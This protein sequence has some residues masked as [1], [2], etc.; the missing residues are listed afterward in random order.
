LPPI[1]EITVNSL[2]SALEAQKG[3]ADRVELCD[4]FAEGGTTP[5]HG[6][7]ITAAWKLEIDLFIIIRPRGGDFLYDDLEF[8][9]MKK[10]IKFARDAGAK[11][12]VF[13]ILLEDGSIDKIRN[14]ELVELAQPMHT[15][16]HRAFDM[17][18]DPFSAVEDIIETGFDR[19]LTSGQ[20]ATAFEGAELISKLVQQANNRIIIMPGSGI[21]ENNILEL[22][23]KTGAREFHGSF[24]KSVP[25]AMIFSNDN[26]NMGNREIGE[27]GLEIADHKQISKVKQLLSQL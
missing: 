13:G 8:E 27:Y 18:S 11:G 21:N 15:T 1:L 25:S 14:R 17:A 16:L 10:D 22:A 19:I 23:R 26:S 20:R 24:R 5:S 2:L 9:V 7:V 12:V 6:M 3:G 4:N